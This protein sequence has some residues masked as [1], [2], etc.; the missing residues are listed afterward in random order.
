MDRLIV[1]GADED[2]RVVL[3]VPAIGRSRKGAADADRLIELD[4]VPDLA[5][6]VVRMRLFVDRG[7]F[8]HENEGT[9][10]AAERGDGFRRHLVQERLIGEAGETDRRAER[11]RDFIGRADEP[12]LVVG[13]VH[14]ARAEE[15]EQFAAGGAGSRQRVELGARV[16]VGVATGLELGGEVARVAGVGE[17]AGIEALLRAAHDHVKGRAAAEAAVHILFGD[18]ELQAAQDRVAAFAGGRRVG[19]FRRGDD[20]RLVAVLALQV[21]PERLDARVIERED[22]RRLR[23]AGLE[24]GII[25]EDA[26]RAFDRLVAGRPRAW[27]SARSRAR[28]DRSSKSSPCR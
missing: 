27:P 28:C 3:R 26:D 20:A 11:R 22:F 17:R 10:A 8:D 24:V 16:D 5:R 12:E 2:E 13:D 19:H 18:V 23:G 7:A 9:A 25:R 14:V 15:A 4:R 6:G 21:F 1:I